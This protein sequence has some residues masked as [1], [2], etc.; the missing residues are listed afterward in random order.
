MTWAGWL[1]DSRLVEKDG[2]LNT[3]SKRRLYHWAVWRY[4]SLMRYS[5]FSLL[6]W[7]FI[8]YISFTIILAAVFYWSNTWTIE[9]M[10]EDQRDHSLNMTERR[11]F[12]AEHKV[13]HNVDHLYEA[14]LLALEMVSTIGYGERGPNSASSVS[15]N[16]TMVTNLLSVALISL[17]S[18]VFLAWIMKS[19]AAEIKF[20]SL[21]VISK[22]DG[23]LALMIRLADPVVSGLAIVEV[24]GFCVL[25][26][27]NH[28]SLGENSR[29]VELRH[30]GDMNFSAFSKGSQTMLPLMWPTVVVHRIDETSPLYTFSPDI[31]ENH[32]LEIIV[33]VT[34]IRDVTGSRILC[35]TSYI[36]DE[37]IWGARF[38]QSA[39]LVRK[40]NVNIGSFGQRDL[41]KVM[42]ERDLPRESAQTLAMMEGDQP[43]SIKRE[44]SV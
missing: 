1:T 23:C 28:S 44:A 5:W 43:V 4:R 37:I 26:R 27:R 36:S 38:S 21:A 31:L 3:V 8:I 29:E 12:E 9:M 15:V 30:M 24:S 39:V 34:G 13:W 6:V 19:Q 25:V 40:G 2:T 18:G 7:C 42:M 33:N 11:K 17:F 10:K 14:F 22:K 41:D 32:S 35:K 16:L 20:S